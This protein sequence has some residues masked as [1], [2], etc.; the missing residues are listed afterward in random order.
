M[1]KE[2]HVTYEQA[3]QLE[4]LGFDQNFAPSINSVGLWHMTSGPGTGR[5][6]A[7][8]VSLAL[9][10][11]QRFNIYIEIALDKTSKPKFA[12]IVFLY[13]EFDT[14]TKLHKEEYVYG[15]L[16]RKYEEAED[17]ALDC[18]LAYLLKQPL[19]ECGCYGECMGHND[20]IK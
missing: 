20:S 19:L 15:A 11:L 12:P 8:T 3:G 1:E 2:K 7:P 9:N 18:A 5:Y 14:Y 6:A 16:F 13:K 17:I 10:W 4:K